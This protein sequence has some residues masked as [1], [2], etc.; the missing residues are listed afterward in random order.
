[1]YSTIIITNKLPYVIKISVYHNQPLLSNIVLSFFY[2]SY[3]LLTSDDAGTFG[4]IVAVDSNTPDKADATVACVNFCAGGV[5][6]A[7]ATACRAFGV[8][9]HV[10]RAVGGPDT[11]Y[12]VDAS[13]FEGATALKSGCG[14]LLSAQQQKAMEAMDVTVE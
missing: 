8:A 14:C 9:A 7:F 1:M 3:F 13:L 12:A 11:G 4:C 10:P 2:V 5:R 6:A